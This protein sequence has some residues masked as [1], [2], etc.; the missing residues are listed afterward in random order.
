MRQRWLI[1]LLGILGLVLGFEILNNSFSLSLI[2][3]GVVC[4]ALYKRVHDRW[5]NILLIVG[6]SSLIFAIFSSRLVLAF[7][8]VGV[9]ILI[10]NNPQLFQLVRELFAQRKSTEKANDFIMV[11]FEDGVEVPA[12]LSRNRWLGEDTQTEDEIYSW[13]DINFTKVAGHTIFDLGNTILPKEQN[14]ILVRQGLGNVK[15][16][17]PE[18]VAI[19]LDISMLLGK[20]FINQEE[21]ALTNERVKWY[22]ANYQTNNRKI[23]LVANVLIGE[24]EVIFL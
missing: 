13:E 11:K 20:V 19:S 21:M 9:L 22:S 1:I 18:G 15:V 16:L 5:Q 6:M 10:G 12:K 14:I 8:L 2:I 17:V 24:V 4:L 23:K 7:V 3:I